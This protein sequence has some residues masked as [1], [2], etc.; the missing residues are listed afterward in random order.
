MIWCIFSQKLWLLLCPFVSYFGNLC[1]HIEKKTHSQCQKKRYK[2]N[3]CVENLYQTLF[4]RGHN[5]PY[6]LFL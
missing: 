3:K 6:K 1:P 2:V 4:S 5:N